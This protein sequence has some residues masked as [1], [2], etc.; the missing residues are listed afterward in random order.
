MVQRVA[1]GTVT[2]RRSARVSVPSGPGS[3]GIARSASVSTGD[4]DAQPRRMPS[5]RRAL[6]PLV[7]PGPTTTPEPKPMDVE[8]FLH[9]VYARQKADRIM[10]HGIGLHRIEAEWD[11]IEIY[12]VSACGCAQAEQLGALGVRVDTSPYDAGRLHPDAESAAICVRETLDWR[13]LPLVVRHARVGDRPEW[14]TRKP[15][16]LLPIL[17]RKGKPVVRYADW[18]KHRN[19]GACPVTYDV[20][21]AYIDMLNETYGTWWDALLLLCSTLNALTGNQRLS[22]RVLPPKA[23]RTPW[24]EDA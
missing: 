14:S 15:Q 23:P 19:Y 10:D 7:V 5:A 18:D 22:R 9:W 1:I 12:G 17:N 24:E 11:D 2:L 21:P 13:T 4:V 3:Y 8:A 16:Q 6:M 20:D